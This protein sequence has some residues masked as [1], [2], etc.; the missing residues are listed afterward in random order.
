MPSGDSLLTKVEDELEALEEDVNTLS[1]FFLVCF[2]TGVTVY[3]VYVCYRPS[4]IEVE[5]ITGGNLSGTELYTIRR[6]VDTAVL[7]LITSYTFFYYS[8]SISFTM[9]NKWFLNSW[10]GGFSFPVTAS[11][12][13]MI[14]KLILIRLWSCNPGKGEEINPLSDHILFW[15]VIPIGAC[16][17]FD[18]ML[19]N[20]S[21]LF[22]NLSMYTIIKSTYC[23]YVYLICVFYGLEPFRSWILFSIFVISCGLSLAVY[24][25]AKINYMGIGMCLAASLFG[26]VRWVLTQYLFKIDIQSRNAFIALYHIAPASA[27]CLIPVSFVMEWERFQQSVFYTDRGIYMRAIICV[28]AG[29]VI[30]FWLLVLEI[31]LLEMTSSV[32]M[33]V[34]GHCKELLQII[35][36]VIIFGEKLTHINVTGL[37]VCSIALMWYKYLTHVYKEIEVNDE[38][39]LPVSQI[40]DENQNNSGGGSKLLNSYHDKHED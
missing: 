14:V 16:T 4:L 1:L 30:A 32:T 5:S 8:I 19:S 26:A 21:L 9:F 25:N 20:S 13:H 28:F 18:V 3:L 7:M 17:A 40:D 15:I 23:I 34:L 11:A 31:K 36:A 22:I 24:S 10:E 27:L 38:K 29:G 6:R 2:G 35:L 37:I 39:Y 12:G 33:G